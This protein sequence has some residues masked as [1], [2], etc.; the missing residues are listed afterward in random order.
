MAEKDCRQRRKRLLDAQ[1]KACRKCKWPD[2]LN[3][4]GV[5][6][7]APGFGSVHSPVA[8]VGEALCRACMATEPVN[9]NEAP[10]RGI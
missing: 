8:V 5:T 7:S 10:L 9:L 4:P 3:E 1:I 6:E 2:R